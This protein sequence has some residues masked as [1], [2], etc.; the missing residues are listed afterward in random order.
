M[1]SIARLALAHAICVQV[2]VER[3]YFHVQ[4]GGSVKVVGVTFFSCLAI[5]I[6]CIRFLKCR[7]ALSFLFLYQQMSLRIVAHRIRSYRHQ[8]YCDNH[9]QLSFQCEVS[10]VFLAT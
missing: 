5:K 9:I 6:G 4:V 1:K 8:S 7:H 2:Q 3:M 10:V